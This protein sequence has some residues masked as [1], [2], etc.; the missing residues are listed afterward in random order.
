[1]RLFRSFL[2]NKPG[3]ELQE[4]VRSQTAQTLPL[5]DNF[6]TRHRER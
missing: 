4:V 6:V 1:L 5:S 2:W 3:K